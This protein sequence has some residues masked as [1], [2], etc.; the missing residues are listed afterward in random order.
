MA[1]TGQERE[2]GLRNVVVDISGFAVTK[3]PSEV[4]VTYSLGSCL[5]LTL[6]DPVAGV[7][8]LVHCMLP[9]S[10]LHP[11]E[12]HRQPGKFVD[13]GVVALLRALFNRGAQPERLVVKAAGGASPS[14]MGGGYFQIG[15]RNTIILRRVLWKN[16]IALAAADLGGQVSRTLCLDIGSGRTVLRSGP[17]EKEL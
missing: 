8:G 16:G 4:L 13:T 5:G 1:L 2:I 11:E 9:L 15:E 3:D 7:A 12:A 14:G 10:R 6:Y 17:H